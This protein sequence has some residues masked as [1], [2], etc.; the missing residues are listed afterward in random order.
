[1]CCSDKQ[2]KKRN[3][4]FGYKMHLKVTPVRE[5]GEDSKIIRSIKMNNRERDCES[6]Q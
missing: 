3:N 5:Y 1:M 6:L 2:G 4:K